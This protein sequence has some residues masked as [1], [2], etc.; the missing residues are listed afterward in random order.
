M[1]QRQINLLATYNT[2]LQ[3]MDDHSNAWATIAPIAD[4]KAEL[5]GGINVISSKGITKQ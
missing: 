3:Y 2:V 1:T 5:S 4:K